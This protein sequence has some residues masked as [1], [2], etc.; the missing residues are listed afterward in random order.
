MMSSNKSVA[1]PEIQSIFLD[2]LRERKRQD[3]LFGQSNQ[4]DFVWLAVL[5]EEVGEAS[6]C[7]L[8]KEF[9]G[10]EAGNLRTELVQVAAVAIAWIENLDRDA[11]ET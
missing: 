5:S 3:D 2:V 8:H 1:P 4:N 6:Q 7:A 9:G 10:N 11:A